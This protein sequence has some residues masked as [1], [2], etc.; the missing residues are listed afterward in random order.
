MSRTGQGGSDSEP[1]VSLRKSGGIGINSAC[2][3]EFFED[4]DFVQLFFDEEGSRL[5][6]KPVAEGVEDSYKINK[7]ENSGSVTPKAFLRR[8]GLVPDVT[9]R[10]GVEWDD[11]EGWLVVDLADE[12]GTYGSPDNDEE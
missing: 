12:R 11:D 6:L 10:Y 1:L 3:N 7:T 9:T 8:E 4:E 2:V 5:A